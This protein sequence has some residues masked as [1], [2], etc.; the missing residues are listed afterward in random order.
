FVGGVTPGTYTVTV[1][2]ST[3][4]TAQAA[5][6]VSAPKIVLTP[7]SGVT[8]ITV[9]ITGGPIVVAPTCTTTLGSGAPSGSFSVGGVPAG[10]YTITLS[11]APAGDSAS[12]SFTVISHPTITLTPSSGPVGAVVVISGVGFS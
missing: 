6:T 4:D 2:G 5:F 1:T 8:G 3:G 10:T 9:T 12:A 11:G 7:N